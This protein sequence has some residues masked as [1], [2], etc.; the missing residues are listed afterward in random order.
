MSP[1]ARKFEHSM[2]LPT[3]AS[4]ILTGTNAFIEDSKSLDQTLAI[5]HHGMAPQRLVQ[6]WMKFTDLLGS[7]ILSKIS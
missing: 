2:N 3:I 7:G 5:S 4:G 6:D 1:A